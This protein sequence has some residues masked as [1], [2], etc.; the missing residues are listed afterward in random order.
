[1]PR[2]VSIRVRSARARHGRRRTRGK[3]VRVAAFTQCCHPLLWRCAGRAMLGTRCAHLLS[4]L[5]LLAA[6]L[7]LA[8][9]IYKWVDD[10]RRRP[11]LGPAAP[12]RA[13]RCDVTGAA[14]LPASANAAGDAGC[15]PSPDSGAADR[16]PVYAGCAHRAAGR[17]RGSSRAS[18]I[19]GQWRCAPSRRCARAIRCFVTLDGQRAEPTA[20]RPARSSPS[21]PSSAARTRCRPR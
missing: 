2:Q 14:D 15:A 5:L 4:T 11:L 18:D 8:A 9:T 20:A 19:A 1:M 6:P 21:A 7:A 17:R 10:E 12:E 16:G 3:G 13:R